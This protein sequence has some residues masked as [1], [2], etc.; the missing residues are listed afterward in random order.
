VIVISRPQNYNEALLRIFVCT[1]I[2]NLVALWLV[3]RSSQSL[4]DL[5]ASFPQTV[6]FSYGAIPLMYVVVAGILSGLFT[7]VFKLHDQ[8]SD[9]FR[10][11]ERFDIQEI[12]IPLAGGVGIPVGLDQL[13]HLRK[14]RKKYMR[15]CFYRFASST[16]PKI[17]GNLIISALD[18]WSLFWVV[19][20]LAAVAFVLMAVTLALKNYFYAAWA[21]VA[22][23]V[24]GFIVSFAHAAC[25]HLAHAEV[26]EILS[27]PEN[28]QEIKNNF[29]AL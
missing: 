17:D 23:I 8:L 7:V 25:A 4:T 13:E 6:K 14:D 27:R 3:V 18:K 26:E 16:T 10:I 5:F 21:G 2:G 11:R 9:L 28:V 20:E 24:G 15:S 22:V 19:L 12:L 29:N 1:F